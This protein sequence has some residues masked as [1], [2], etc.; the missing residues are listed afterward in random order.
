MKTALDCLLYDTRVRYKLSE[1]EFVRLSKEGS[2]AG[3][4]TASLLVVS[5]SESKIGYFGLKLFVRRRCLSKCTFD[6]R[7]FFF[8]F[9]TH[10][11]KA[12]DEKRSS[13]LL[14]IPVLYN[15]YV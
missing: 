1:L 15:I 5:R 2:Q 4:R 13:S 14:E 7:F 8:F 9:I 10:S 6:S 3:V 12:E 11:T